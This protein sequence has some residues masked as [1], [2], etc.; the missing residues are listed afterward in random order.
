MDTDLCRW[1]S[2]AIY[3]IMREHGCPDFVNYID[4]L[5]HCDLPSNIHHDYEFLVHLLSQLGLPSEAI[6]VL[7]C[8]SVMC[9]GVLVDIVSRTIS[10]LPEKCA[11]IFNIF[12]NWEVKNKCTKTD[13]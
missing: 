3:F 6:L 5:I 2:D 8:M 12:H 11:E 9:L 10:I 7:S 13:L 4:D 1:C